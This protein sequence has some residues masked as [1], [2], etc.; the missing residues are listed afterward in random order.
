MSFASLEPEDPLSPQELLNGYH[1]D[2][3]EPKIKATCKKW[4][5]D[6][7]KARSDRSC[8][9]EPNRPKS[10]I[11]L[12][13]TEDLNGIDDVAKI[14]GPLESGRKDDKQAENDV[15]LTAVSCSSHILLL[16]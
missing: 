10:R 12:D 16:P 4:V 1:C 7:E 8:H 9:S 6:V 14:S 2:D 13:L 5:E 3:L 15:G 11:W